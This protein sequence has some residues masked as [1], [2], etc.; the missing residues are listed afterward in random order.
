MENNLVEKNL[1]PL[2]KSWIIRM[3]FLDVIHGYEDINTFLEKQKD[4]N[5]DL[6]SLKIVC[7]EWN[8]QD[9]IHV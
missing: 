5:D 6:L 8:T 4:L 9:D 1:I 2:D 3:G 7:K